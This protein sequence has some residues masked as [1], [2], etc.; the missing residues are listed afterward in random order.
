VGYVL[1][2]IL[3]LAF[4]GKSP[5]QCLPLGL[6]RCQA[7]ALLAGPGAA[8]PNQRKVCFCDFGP[9]VV[10]RAGIC[11]EPEGSFFVRSALGRLL[12]GD[13]PFSCTCV[14]ESWASAQ[15]CHAGPTMG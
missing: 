7:V 10:L 14:M 11:F 5:L 6:E 13:F 12:L 4:V 15:G 8:Q 1:T 9:F 3:N 2:L